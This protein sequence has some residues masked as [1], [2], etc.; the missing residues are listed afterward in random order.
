M[1]WKC[2][3]KSNYAHHFCFIPLSVGS[4][5]FSAN[6]RASNHTKSC[7]HHC[8]WV[9]GW[10]VVV[11]GGG[12]ERGDWTPLFLYLVCVYCRFLQLPVIVIQGT[13]NTA[14]TC[15]SDFQVNLS[16]EQVCLWYNYL[17]FGHIINI[18]SKIKH[19]S[20]FLYTSAAKS[21]QS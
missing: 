16:L 18:Q 15:P 21:M 6:Q 10:V 20:V 11:G 17:S 3:V 5:N 4:L 2:N 8:G 7:E 9:G 1:N 13:A 12:G 19:Q 14:S